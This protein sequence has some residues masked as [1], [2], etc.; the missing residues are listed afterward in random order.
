MATK[1]FA[2]NS[3][4]R[5]ASQ[6]ENLNHEQSGSQPLPDGPA[7][8]TSL[9]RKDDISNSTS[10]SNASGCSNN[11]TNTNVVSDPVDHFITSAYARFQ[12]E[13]AS[14]YPNSTLPFEEL[15]SLN[16]AK[17]CLKLQQQRVV[18]LNK[19]INKAKFSVKFLQEIISHNEKKDFGNT[20]ASF[21]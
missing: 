19:E 4:L 18:D 20:F 21:I 9:P 2:N 14:L 15:N 6:F 12:H 11:C 10:T 17:E 16:E 13:Y 7:K 5:R 8:R 1:H 3:V